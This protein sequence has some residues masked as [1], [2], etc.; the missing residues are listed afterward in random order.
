MRFAAI[1]TAYLFWLIIALAGLFFWANSRR[2]KALETFAD[3]NLLPTLLASFD[4]RKHRIKEML[5][6]VAL[7]LSVF[8][9]MRPQWGF[10]WHKIQRKGLDILVAVDVSKSMLAEDI[11]PNRLE[12]TKLALADFVKRL[13]GDR[14]GLIA[15]SGSAFVQC[16]LTIDYSG[17]L[18]SVESLDINTIPKSGTS[19]SSAIRQALESYE[20]GLKK[21]K[22][23]I[24]ITDGEDHEGDPVKAAES[25]KDTGIKIFCIGIG[26]NEGELIP[27]TDEN[28]N[29]AF[30]KDK[31]GAV[32]KSRLDEAVLQKIALTTGGSY[33]RASAKE[34]GLDLIYREKLSEME[35]RE[36]ESKMAKQ[37]EERFQIPLAIAFLLLAA[38][39]LLSDRRRLASK[40]L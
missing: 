33:V 14:I 16:P 36:L 29:K 1:Q 19:I 5:V 11:K 9:L 30:L 32:V 23:L 4:S 3:I 28:G 10:K 18:L 7:T 37:Y 22:V 15:F 40:V 21:Y 24:I 12:R 26:T 6:I 17:F 25:A 31:S 34:F 8:A 13:K 20:G 27:V 35:K 38:E 39:F 2:K